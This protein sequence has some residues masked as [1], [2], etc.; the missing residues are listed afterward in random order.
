MCRQR[1]RYALPRNQVHGIPGV[2]HGPLHADRLVEK[3]QRYGSRLAG[4]SGYSTCR[5]LARHQGVFPLQKLV[6]VTTPSTV[7]VGV[8]DVRSVVVLSCVEQPVIVGVTV[9]FGAA[10][11]QVVTPYR[12]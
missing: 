5:V 12:I 8:A 11:R 6:K 4:G 2:A 3:R 9:G 10:D 7:T 1:D